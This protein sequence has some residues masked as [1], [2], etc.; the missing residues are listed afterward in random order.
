MHI[1]QQPTLKV[2][3]T[4]SAYTISFRN[5]QSRLNFHMIEWN[6]ILLDT[7]MLHNKMMCHAQQPYTYSQG[8]IHNLGSN[9]LRLF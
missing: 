7:I 2:K 4:V 6:L 3:V 9:I 5:F 8:Q 1:T